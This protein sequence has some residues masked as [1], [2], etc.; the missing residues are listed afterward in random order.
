MGDVKT[1]TPLRQ[2]ARWMTDAQNLLALIVAVAGLVAQLLPG[3]RAAWLGWL[4]LTVALV[5]MVWL[6]VSARRAWTRPT[7]PVRPAEGPAVQIRGAKPF[8]DG[9]ELMGRNRETSEVFTTVRALEFRFG[10][11]SGQAGA[12]KTSLLRAGLTK[13][14]RRETP[15]WTFVYAPRAGARPDL[16]IL[17]ALKAKFPDRIPSASRLSEA[18]QTILPTLEAP[19]LVACDQF[20]E[21]FLAARS[22]ESRAVVIDEFKKLWELSR[23]DGRLRL[24]FCLRK[25]FVDDLL[26]M[27]KALPELR[28]HDW[29]SSLSNLTLETTCEMLDQLVAD[30]EINMSAQLRRRVASDLAHDGFIRPVELQIVL[31]RLLEHQV[32]DLPAYD[33]RGGAF[34]ILSGFIAE[35]LD[36]PDKEVSELERQVGRHLLRALCADNFAARK[37]GGLAQGPLVERVWEQLRASAGGTTFSR[38]EVAQAVAGLIAEFRHA[39]VLV[40]ED[41]DRVNLAHD[42][43]AAAVRQATAD[44][45]SAEERAN[46]LLDQYVGQAR[47]SSSSVIPFR[48]LRYIRR[49]ASPENR[50]KTESRRLMSRSTRWHATAASGLAIMLLALV[51]WALP[52]GWR[53]HVVDRIEHKNIEIVS[54]SPPLAQLP[55]G[56]GE[57]TG[58]RIFRLDRN[59]LVRALP[60]VRT[61]FDRRG[62]RILAGSV[63]GSVFL[64]EASDEFRPRMLLPRAGWNTEHLTEGLGGFSADGETAYV[65]APRGELYIKR[66]HQPIT[67]TARFNVTLSP[68]NV[69]SSRGQSETINVPQVP[70]VVIAP[71]GR[72]IALLV[73]VDGDKDIVLLDTARTYPSLPA[74]IGRIEMSAL[75]APLFSPDGAHL[76]WQE[77]QTYGSEAVVQVRNLETGRAV[78]LPIPGTDD[79]RFRNPDVYFSDDSKWLLVRHVGGNFDQWR[80]GSAP[81]VRRAI[82]ASEYGNQ[83]RWQD[84]VFDPSG[85]FVLGMASN[86][87]IHLWELANPPPRQSRPLLSDTGGFFEEVT[88]TAAFCPSGSSGMLASASGTLY[89]FPLVTQ[90]E[91]TATKRLALGQIRFL[92]GE[93]EDFVVAFNTSELAFGPCSQGELTTM[94][95]DAKVE[96]VGV[97]EDGRDLIVVDEAGFS[98][99]R[100]SFMVWGLPVYSAEFPRIRSIFRAGYWGASS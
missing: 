74:P 56:E 9:D 22:A 98:R 30:G 55:A 23:D 45:E 39:R 17:K 61:Y 50:N 19:V 28:I 87:L 34:G 83:D 12:G 75:M 99:V 82:T 69:E 62:T 86:G 24:L 76:A 88:Q 13:R 43:L 15:Q 92:I 14:L 90:P 51:T 21:F 40:D 18:F 16:E 44:I 47:L 80:V 46:R 66:R 7:S 54:I 71:G 96:G 49:Y 6:A 63:N 53:V 10:Y 27:A 32:R 84:P 11:L 52:F 8:E 42:Y 77:A 79:F 81:R 35:T 95:F 1:E 97:S 58:T 33:R 70:E 29:R 57:A 91:L 73:E 36:P 48:T 37:P 93:S 72:H 89:R 2:L 64:A 41:E 94:R 78:S 65:I 4:A 20:E 85:R 59:Q 38:D 68:V 3:F 31:S 60:S 67:L 25:E 100:R 26:S 5:A